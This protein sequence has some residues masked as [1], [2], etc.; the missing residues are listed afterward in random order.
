MDRLNLVFRCS[1]FITIYFFQLIWWLWINSMTL[2]QNTAHS[3][4]WK[5]TDYITNFR[6]LSRKIA[7]K[8]LEIDL[9]LWL[10]WLRWLFLDLNSLNSCNSLILLHTINSSSARFFTAVL[11][12]QIFCHKISTFI[13]FFCFSPLFLNIFITPNP[14]KDP[15]YF[16]IQ[17]QTENWK[18]KVFA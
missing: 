4:T 8:T 14:R 5:I 11:N 13:L 17:R 18:L 9:V 1:K 12:R 7:C 3:Q 16:R 15:A 10:F 6:F 2:L